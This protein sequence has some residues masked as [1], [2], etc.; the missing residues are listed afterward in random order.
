[1]AES[2]CVFCKIVRRELSSRVVFENNKIIAFEDSNP[3]GPVHL[4]IIPK[5]HIEKISDLTDDNACLIGELILTAK[6]LACRQGISDTGYRIVLNCGKDAGQEVL[7]L[8]LHLLGGR[9]FTWPPG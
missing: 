3:Q 8:H 7:H 4:L 5:N 1:M 9:S 6:M 2:D